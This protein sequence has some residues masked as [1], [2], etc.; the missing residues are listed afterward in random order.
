MRARSPPAGAPRSADGGGRSAEFLRSTGASGVALSSWLPGLP[1]VL[2]VSFL[3]RCAGLAVVPGRMA[4]AAAIAPVSLAGHA[5]E[6]LDPWE[7]PRIGLRAV[8]LGSP[9][10][11]IMAVFRGS[12]SVERGMAR[13]SV[14]VKVAAA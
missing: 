13:L 10:G 7:P 3:R 6:R 8:D 2:A 12:F 11:P 9:A 1:V 4:G 5:V 14:T